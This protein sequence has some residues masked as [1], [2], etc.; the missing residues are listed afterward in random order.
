MSAKRP[1]ARRS[2]MWRSVSAYGSAG[3]A[4]TASS[5]SSLRR[6]PRVPPRSR[7]IVCRGARGPDPRGRRP[8][9]ARARGGARSRAPAPGEVLV[10]LRASALNHLDVWIRKGPAVGAEAAHPR[11]RRRRRRRGA[12]RRRDRLRARRARRPQPGHRDGERPIHVIGEHGDGTNA[13]LIAVP[14]TNVHPIPDGS[15][16]RGGGGVPARLRDRVPDARHARRAC[17]R[18]SGCSPGASAAASRPRRSRSRRRSGRAC[19]VTSSSDAKLAR[20]RELGADV[21]VNHATGDVKARCKEATDGHGVDVVVEHVGEATWA[22]SLDVAAPGGRITVCG[23]TTGPNPPAALHRIWWKQL[24]I[25][26]STM[27]TARGLRR[28]LRARRE[29]PRAARRRLGLPARGDPR[30]ARAARGRRAARQ[31]R[32][33]DLMPFQNRV[34]PLGELVASA[35]RG[36]VYGNRG[37]LHDEPATSDRE[38]QLDALDLLPAG[39]PRPLPGRRAA[40]AGPLHGALLPRRGDRARGRAPA[41]RR[42]PQ[43]RLPQLSRAHGSNPRATSST[44]CCTRSA[45]ACTPRS[46]TTFLTAPSWYSTGQPWLVLDSELLRWTAGGYTERRPRFSGG[47]DVVTPPTSIRRPSLG[48]ERRPAAH[49]SESTGLDCGMKKRPKS[50]SVVLARR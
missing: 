17:A 33:R 1:R 5:P 2:R 13:E 40:G 20:A 36:L 42:V 22:T 26:G 25:L 12:R 44:G 45:G 3:A 50:S 4:P 31:D 27:G 39:V 29:R 32:P 48:L 14:A 43:R 47:G 18:A 34:T 19:I 11:R 49:P 23:A 35:E 41:V 21:A 7:A 30:R 16:L 28:R 37:R 9:G 10:R 38:W 46:W 6:G 15:E 24:S 8:G